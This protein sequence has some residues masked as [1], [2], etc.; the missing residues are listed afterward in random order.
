MTTST[1]ADLALVRD[2]LTNVIAASSVLG[3]HDPLADRAASA[4]ERI[5][6]EHIARD[7]LLGEWYDDPPDA[8]PHHRHQSHLYGLLPGDALLPWTD[9]ELCRAAARSLDE[10]GRES[11]GWSLAWRVGLRARLRDAAGAHAALL[12]FLAPVRDPDNPGPS[13]QAGLYAN[14]FCAHPPFQ[15]DGNFGVAAAIL[16]MIVQSHAGRIA[17]LPA[18]PLQWPGGQVRGVRVRG[19]AEI[20]LAWS[21]GV[22]TSLTIRGSIGSVHTV[23]MLG[24]VTRVTIG[25]SGSTR[26]SGR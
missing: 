24:E 8:D 13:G 21:E 5:P 22:P 16:E 11:T 12:D 23:E 14:L 1:T 10:R 6:R 19:G 2:L 4:L 20:D 9:P 26:V 17:I 3:N 25:P 15:I 7:G 18:L